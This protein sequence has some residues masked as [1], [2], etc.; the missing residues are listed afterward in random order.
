M[1]SAMDVLVHTSLREGIA[2]MLPQALTMGKPCVSFDLDG[3][4]EVVIP[5][6]PA[7]SWRPATRRGCRLRCAGC[8]A[9]PSCGSASE[10][11]VGGWSTR[12]TGQRRWSS[13]SR[14]STA[15]Y[16]SSAP[17]TCV[18]SKTAGTC[19]RIMWGSARRCAP[20]SRTR[21]HNPGRPANQ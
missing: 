21:Y 12:C 19:R 16:W 1:I 4:P 7:S 11:G 2:R 14:T 6:Q 5:G 18:A 15:G 3:A 17:A 9:I 10:T 13:R 8:W 20:T